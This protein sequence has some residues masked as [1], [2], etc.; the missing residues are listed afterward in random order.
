MKT[1]LY[2]QELQQQ[3]IAYQGDLMIM[4]VPGAK[5]SRKNRVTEYKQGFISL[6]EGEGSGHHHSVSVKEPVTKEELRSLEMDLEAEKLER[7]FEST[8]TPT[9]QLFSDPD[10]ARQYIED[11]SLHIGFLEIV[12]APYVIKHVKFTG[13][14]STTP[15]HEHDGI[16]LPAGTYLIG[17]QREMNAAE[18]ARVSD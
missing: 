17:A 11:T 9:A 4:P 3:G 2:S 12:G 5:F 13:A 14:N 1:I 8:E 15:T 18:I 16:M 7:L 6:L 10:A